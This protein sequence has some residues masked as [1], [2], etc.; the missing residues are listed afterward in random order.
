[1][2]N[3]LPM[4]LMIRSKQIWAEFEASGQTDDELGEE[5]EVIKH[6]LRGVKREQA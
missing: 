3:R 5:L 4:P 1:M 2:V 6:K